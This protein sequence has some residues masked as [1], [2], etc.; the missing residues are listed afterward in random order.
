V[1][2]VLQPLDRDHLYVAGLDHGCLFAV[3]SSSSSPDDATLRHSPHLRQCRVCLFYCR[4]GPLRRYLGPRWLEAGTRASLVASFDTM[5]LT[6]PPPTGWPTPALP[7]T[8]L[9]LWARYLGPTSTSLSSFLYRCGNQFHGS[10][11]PITLLGDLVL[12]GTFYL[13]A[14]LV[15]PHIIQNLLSICRFTTDNSC[16]IEFDPFG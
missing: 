7:T 6:P 9:L 12:P 3:S 13:N 16:S 5:A 8:P 10:T 15:A 1:A 14:I 11:L 4:R 2:V